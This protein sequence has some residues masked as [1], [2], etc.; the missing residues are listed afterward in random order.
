M[1][2]PFPQLVKSELDQMRRLALLTH[3]DHFRAARYVDKHPELFN[4]RA[5]L[6]VSEAADLA[7][8]RAQ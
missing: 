5:A 7:V 2:K 1:P 4:D 8:A 3:A 6:Q